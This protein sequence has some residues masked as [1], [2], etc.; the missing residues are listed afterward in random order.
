MGG[1]ETLSLSETSSLTPI[2][3]ITVLNHNYPLN[4]YISSLFPIKE[5]KG[6]IQWQR[7]GYL[8][9]E[10]VNMSIVQTNLLNRYNSVVRRTNTLLLLVQIQGQ[11]QSFGF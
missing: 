11:G 4:A 6:R 2:A 3:Y 1:K 7:Q 5:T 10:I 9:L 8:I